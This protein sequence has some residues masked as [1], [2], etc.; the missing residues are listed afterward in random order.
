[1]AT[2]LGEALSNIPWQEK[3]HG[4]SG[5]VWRYTANPIIPRNLLPTS[6]SIFNSIMFLI[7]FEFECGNPIHPSRIPK[8]FPGAI[9]S[10][11]CQ[12]TSHHNNSSYYSSYKH[13]SSLLEM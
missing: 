9:H 8:I 12:D 10:R 3:P 4:E 2:I 6:N 1:M 13:S 11:T 5:V 7:N